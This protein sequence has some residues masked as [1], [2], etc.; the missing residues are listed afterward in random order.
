MLLDGDEVWPEKTIKELFSVISRFDDM[1]SAVVIPA[2]VPVGDLFHC[3]PETAGRYNILGKKGHYN[4][5]LYKVGNYRWR[6][7]YPF[8]AYTDRHGQ[9]IQNQPKKLYLLK[10]S[11]W[12][13]THLKRSVHDDHGRRKLE[14]GIVNNNNIP[15]VF[16]KIHPPIVPT[17]FIKTNGVETMISHLVTPLKKI[18]REFVNS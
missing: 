4:I 2:I 8:E 16:Y 10:N 13:L 15:E 5:R 12:H 1:K 7:I 11:Y 9:V 6:G 18:K 14:L 3:Q 17:P